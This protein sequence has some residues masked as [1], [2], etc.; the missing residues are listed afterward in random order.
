MTMTRLEEY[1]NRIAE[2]Y[3][4]RKIETSDTLQFSK[5]NS[6]PSKH[7]TD[8]L[9]YLKSKYRMDGLAVEGIMEEPKQPT[10]ADAV[11]A[12]EGFEARGEKIFAIAG[13][14]LNSQP[15]RFWIGVKLY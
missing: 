9:E 7:E 11:L 8:R 2:N 3:G 5:Q 13:E 1:Q 15:M 4:I 12:K 6:A 14:G 10:L